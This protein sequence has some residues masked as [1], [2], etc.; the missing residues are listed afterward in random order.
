MTG[1]RGDNIHL[2]YTTYPG[3][4]YGC[5]PVKDFSMAFKASTMKGHPLA[6]LMLL[7]VTFHNYN[8]TMYNA[9]ELGSVD[10]NGR[11]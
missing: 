11:S 4:C 5:F 2:K 7:Y 1:A 3:V 9:F 6:S 10:Y 8:K